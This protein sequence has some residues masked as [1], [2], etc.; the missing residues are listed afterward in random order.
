MP[1]KPNL[2]SMALS[3]LV[4]VV[5]FAALYGLGVYKHP[6][7]AKRGDDGWIIP[8]EE[9]D[10]PQSACQAAGFASYN[11]CRE[12]FENQW[13]DGGSHDNPKPERA[14]DYSRCSRVEERAFLACRSYGE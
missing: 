8:H 13:G 14:L 1:S 6:V 9:S 12:E 5:I 3:V 2:R 10:K 7:V 4:V 11:Q